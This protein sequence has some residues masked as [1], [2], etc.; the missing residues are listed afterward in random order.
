LSPLL[1][2]LQGLGAVPQPAAL[3]ATPAEALLAELCG[4]LA[5]ERGLAAVT[6]RRYVRSYAC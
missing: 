3:P 5:G 2:Y 6:V 1:G 4:Y